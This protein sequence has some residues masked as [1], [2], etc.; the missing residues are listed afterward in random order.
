MHHVYHLPE[1][2]DFY[3]NRVRGMQ[4][5]AADRS[6]GPGGAGGSIG[7]IHTRH[8]QAPRDHA[9]SCALEPG[10]TRPS[11]D[12]DG[13]SHRT[14]VS[15]GGRKFPLQRGA[16]TGCCAAPPPAR[17]SRRGS[18]GISSGP[19]PPRSCLRT[20]AVH[21]PSPGSGAV[22]PGGAGSGACPSAG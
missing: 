11:G 13:L 18:G 21:T 2:E 19:G 17:R 8:P 22:P 14:G 9:S 5:D 16:F 4:K 6:L 20:T 12:A 10:S 7:T 3:P 1:V 15:P